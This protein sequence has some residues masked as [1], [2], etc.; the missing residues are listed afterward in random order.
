[1]QILRQGAVFRG[2]LWFHLCNFLKPKLG[3]CAAETNPGG[4]ARL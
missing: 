3:Y 4:N 1:M 2:T